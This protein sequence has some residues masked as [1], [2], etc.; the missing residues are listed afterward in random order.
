V[1]TLV[2]WGRCLPD[3][4]PDVQIP[5]SETKQVRFAGIDCSA[6]ALD[7][8]KSALLGSC[9]GLAPRNISLVCQEYTQ[10]G[11]W[12]RHMACACIS[13]PKGML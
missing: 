4:R 11:G 5:D 7:M 8:A 9:E 13:V 12:C 2:L 6:A 3:A 10:G 1:V